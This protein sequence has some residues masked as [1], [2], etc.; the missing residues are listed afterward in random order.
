M[1]QATLFFFSCLFISMATY[2]QDFSVFQSKQLIH[3]GDTLPYRILYPE[4]YD[5]EGQY[6]VLFFLHGAGERGNDNEKQ[7]L[8]GGSLFLTDSI[9]NA[10]PAI[11][12]FPQ[13][14]TDSYWSNVDIQSQNGVREFYFRTG[15]KPSVGMALFLRLVKD[16]L[17]NEAVVEQRVYI[18]GLSMGGMGT[19][20]ALR[21]MRNVFAAAF[22]I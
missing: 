22:S 20:E 7:L 10:F 1:K 6:P 9:R 5:T 16:V 15:G 17:K 8:H 14:P 21:R 2:A 13:C 12:V 18:G 19:Y 3:R 4:N 11:V